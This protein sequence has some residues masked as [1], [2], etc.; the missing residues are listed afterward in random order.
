[1][2]VVTQCKLLTSKNKIFCT[3]K[4]QNSLSSIF[5]T[6]CKSTFNFDYFLFTFHIFV[7]IYMKYIGYNF[8]DSSFHILQ[9]MEDIVENVR[10]IARNL[11]CIKRHFG[12]SI[13]RLNHPSI[14]HGQLEFLPVT[15]RPSHLSYV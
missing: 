6:I 14:H 8:T 13:D 2:R 7:L 12:R 5:F 4:I 3:Q 10:K 15:M 1:M 11:L 9:E